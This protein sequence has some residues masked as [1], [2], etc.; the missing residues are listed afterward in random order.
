MRVVIPVVIAI[1]VAATSVRAQRPPEQGPSRRATRHRAA[2]LISTSP[3][4]SATNKLAFPSSSLTG[5][6]GSRSS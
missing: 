6:D 2:K 3:G 5:E 1:V 4:S